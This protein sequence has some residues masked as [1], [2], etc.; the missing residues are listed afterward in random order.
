MVNIAQWS[1]HRHSSRCWLEAPAGSSTE[2]FAAASGRR[3]WLSVG[4]AW[5]AG[6]DRSMWRTLRPSAGQAQQWVSVLK[7]FIWQCCVMFV[8]EDLAFTDRYVSMS[9]VSPWGQ[10]AGIKRYWMINTAQW[11]CIVNWAPLCSKKCSKGSRLTLD[12]FSAFGWDI[13]R[14]K[15]DS[16]LCLMICHHVVFWRVGSDVKVTFSEHS[17]RTIKSALERRNQ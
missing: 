4:A 10:V 2:K 9:H 3:H 13:I 8:I 17:S 14:P 1:P 16:F 5:I 12:R 6:Q 15:S 11:Q 7:G